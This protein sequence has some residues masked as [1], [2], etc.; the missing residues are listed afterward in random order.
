MARFGVEELLFFVGL[1]L[2][3]CFMRKINSSRKKGFQN[4]EFDNT[5]NNSEKIITH[6]IQKA[7]KYVEKKISLSYLT[8]CTWALQNNNLNIL[9]TF[10]DNGELLVTTGGIV[11][12]SSYE[13]IIDNNSILISKNDITE[14]YNIVN[15]QNDF[16]YLNRV[17]SNE[18]LIFSNQTKYK[19]IVKSGI[20][21]N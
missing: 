3:I 11:E 19:D 1:I 8:E 6:N 14:L 13:L 10:R 2:F 4:S 18:I 12:K 7:K 20:Y 21:N 17:S 16:L 9:Y 15:V 5:I